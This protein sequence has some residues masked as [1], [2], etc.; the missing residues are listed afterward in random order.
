[1]LSTN[2]T[3]RNSKE[4]PEMEIVKRDP[5]LAPYESAIKGRHDHAF[6]EA[7]SAYSRRKVLVVRIC[8][9][10]I[11]IMVFIMSLMVGF[12]ANGLQMLQTFIL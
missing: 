9:L 7:E 12:F 2:Q 11:S 10:A 6:M 8:K 5:Y 3:K 1:M 4:V